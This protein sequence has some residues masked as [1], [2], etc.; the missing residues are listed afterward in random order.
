MSRV[1]SIII[2]NKQFFSEKKHYFV[3][4]MYMA[5]HYRISNIVA[6]SDLPNPNS[7]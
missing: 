1:C 4:C 3:L 5:D 7:L 6:F 2:N